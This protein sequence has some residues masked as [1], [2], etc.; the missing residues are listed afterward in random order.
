MIRSVVIPFGKGGMIGGTMLGL[1]RALGETIV[2]ALIIS[3]WLST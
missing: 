2:V 3:P 1:G